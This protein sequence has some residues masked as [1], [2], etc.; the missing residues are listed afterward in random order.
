MDSASADHAAEQWSTLF[1]TCFVHRIRASQLNKPFSELWSTQPIPGSQLASIIFTSG[2][3]GVDPLIT[4]YLEQ[5]LRVTT[6]DTCDILV[7]LLAHSRYALKK[8]AS[9]RTPLSNA[10][11]EHVL[12]LL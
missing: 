2:A 12:S 3:S 11:F 10:F 6:T 1:R 8:K 9:T 5:I 7:A 4:E